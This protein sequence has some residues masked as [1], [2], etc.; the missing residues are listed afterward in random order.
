M[1]SVDKFGCM[2]LLSTREGNAMFDLLK[3]ILI[4]CASLEEVHREL[5]KV[6]VI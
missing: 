3:G 2:E 4:T 1:E 6:V 5:F